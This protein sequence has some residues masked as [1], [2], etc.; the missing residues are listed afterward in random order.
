MGFSIKTPPAD[1]FP[2]LHLASRTCLKPRCL[3]GREHP[4]P[5]HCSG[6]YRALPAP[7]SSTRWL[8]R[9]FPGSGEG[10]EGCTHGNSA[11][12]RKRGLC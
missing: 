9:A 4:L 12:P 7:F 5:W 10:R 3:S 6:L 11:P 1:V 2:G 8:L